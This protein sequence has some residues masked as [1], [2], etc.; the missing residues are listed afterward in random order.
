MLVDFI[1]ASEFEN[2]Y[3]VSSEDTAYEPFTH[4]LWG[5]AVQEVHY[6]P[7]KAGHTIL[8]S[9]LY[10]PGV[11]E[12]EGNVD[13]VECWSSTGNFAGIMASNCLYRITK[14]GYLVS[15]DNP[16][17]FFRTE[18]EREAFLGSEEK[19]DQYFQDLYFQREQK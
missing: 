3:I 6:E 14:D 2:K 4:H 1:P 11:H 9:E 13:V 18:E 19:R 5:L 10:A 16:R 7:V 8:R 15:T 12:G 17:F